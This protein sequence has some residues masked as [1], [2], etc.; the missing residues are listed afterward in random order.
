MRLLRRL[1]I[2]TIVS[3]VMVSLVP[4]PLY[5]QDFTDLF[6][7]DVIT[8]VQPMTG[9]VYWE[10]SGRN[11][12][13]VISLEFSYMLFNQV[14]Q[15]SGVYNW[16]EVDARLSA[17]AARGH[18]AIFR[19]RYVYP[20][21]ETSVPGYILQRDDYH[22]TVGL[23]EGK[24]THFPD[25]TNGELKRFT[26]EF[27]TRF[28]GRYDNDPRLAFIQVGFG[29]W[30]EYHIY[31]GPFILGETFP[32]KEFQEVFFYHL[33]ST[34]QQVPWSI[35]VDAADDTYSPFVE[36]P[37]LKD[38][39]FGVFD[40]SFMHEHHSQWNEIEWNFFGRQRYRLS[41]AGGEFSYYSH[42]D[43][44]HVL[45]YP[46]GP[47]GTPYETWAENFHITYMLANDQ[48]SYQT[49]ERIKEASMASGYRFKIVSL[50]TAA[51]TSVFEVTNVGVAP[52]YYDAWFAVDGVR[53]GQTLKLLSPGDTIVF[54]VAAGAAEAVI[55][56]ESDR[57]VEGQVI[58]FYG[59]QQLTGTVSLSGPTA[60]AGFPYP[61]PV[62]KGELV[63][64]E[65]G[66]DGAR[67][68]Y[69]VYDSRGRLALSGS[70]D[71]GLVAI[72]TCQLPRGVYLLRTRQEKESAVNRFMVL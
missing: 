11:N 20:G 50:R 12:T 59:T 19:F 8:A 52:F 26:L 60:A 57:L 37:E 18:Q 5:S 30:A 7:D 42:Y 38:L 10:N 32:S 53:S 1:V 16:D 49:Q 9:M 58:Q 25:W 29:L 45:D 22:E 61:N 55:T 66:R 68:K 54:G 51:D 43:Q 33:D 23:S 65:S 40:D 46:G 48:P 6:P 35:S 67:V 13:E 41:P 27:Y 47:Y 24:E 36:K 31:D 15:D 2:M 44:A 39:Q 63:Y 64:L 62:R 56:I 70:S 28:A 4:V 3:V 72:P 14:V 71:P 17:I 34:F 21:Y 69:D